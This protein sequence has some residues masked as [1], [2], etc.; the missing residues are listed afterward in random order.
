MCAIQ[1]V[2]CD[3][4]S[5]SLFYIFLLLSFPSFRSFMPLLLP[6]ALSLTLKAPPPALSCQI[7]GPGISGGK[8]GEKSSFLVSIFQHSPSNDEE[9]REE[10]KEGGKANLEPFAI[11]PDALTVQQVLSY[12][13]FIFFLSRSSLSSLF[14]PSPITFF[15]YSPPSSRR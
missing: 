6:H 14:L 8:V 11:E 5:S 1:G 9:E 12:P 3:S 4:Q 13:S 10:R 15:S 7:S 2:D